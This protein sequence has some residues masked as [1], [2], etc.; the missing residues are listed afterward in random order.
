MVHHSDLI[1]IGSPFVNSPTDDKLLIACFWSVK[2]ERVAVCL[3]SILT[4]ETVWIKEVLC[5]NTNSLSFTEQ[6][7]IGEMRSEKNVLWQMS[8][9]QSVMSSGG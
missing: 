2:R 5:C 1:T 7:M 9:F 4:A 8:S 3:I 6:Y